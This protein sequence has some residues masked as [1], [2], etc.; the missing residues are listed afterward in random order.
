MRKRKQI[1]KIIIYGIWIMYPPQ[2]KFCILYSKCAFL[3]FGEYKLIKYFGTKKNIS[4][5]MLVFS[6]F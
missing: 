5:L 4:R 1:P 2:I 6:K 3:V